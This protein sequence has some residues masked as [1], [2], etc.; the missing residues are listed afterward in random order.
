[1]DVQEIESAICQ[2]PRAQLTELAT[3]FEQFHGQLW[4]VQIEQDSRDRR[5]DSLLK[6][7]KQDLASGRCESL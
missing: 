6:E 1:M 2:L 5:L 4:D 7:T 3:W